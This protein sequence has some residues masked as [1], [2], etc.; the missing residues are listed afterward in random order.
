MDGETEGYLGGIFGEVSPSTPS[1][2]IATVGSVPFCRLLAKAGRPLLTWG[3]CETALAA[4]VGIES[5]F[6]RLEDF[7]RIATRYPG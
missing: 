3:R 2:P 6:N 7:R 5:A 4:Y 1:M